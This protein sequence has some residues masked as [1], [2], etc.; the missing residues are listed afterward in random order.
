MKIVI[1][2]GCGFLGVGIAR[3]LMDRPEIDSL[4]LFDAHVPDA[5]PNGLD[6]RVTMVEGDISDRVQVAAIID[7]DDIGVF[8]LAS[9]VSA[10]GEQ[11]FDLAMRVNFDGGRHILEALR[12]R[13]GTPRIVL[14]SSLAVFGG[15]D[16]PEAVTEMTRV[17]PQTTYG[18]TKAIGELMINDYTRKGF[19]DGRAARLPTVIIRPGAPNAAASGFASGVFREP[20]SGQDYVLP[21]VMDTRMMVI[22]AR[23]AI[24]GL[25]GL[26]DA[27]G[28]GL[29][30]DR[31]VNLP[32]N[33]YAVTDMIA[34]LE[35]VAAENGITFGP[36][37]PKPDPAIEAIVKSWPLT[38]EDSR[39]RALGLPAD[40]SLEAIIREYIADW[41]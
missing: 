31:V 25:T 18:M 15:P 40:E 8:H 4:V 11:D 14:A 19:I 23:S 6:D 10:G 24:A 2:G 29:G 33:A 26:M 12:A 7:R 39:A 32:N 20:L 21:V 37:T 41:L 34:A 16:M 28:E 3:K 30:A 1:T 22:G 38:M 5:L 9:V 17:V 13:K 36:V 35:R 27:D